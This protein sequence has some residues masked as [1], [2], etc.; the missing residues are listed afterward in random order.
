[1]VRT[2]KSAPYLGNVGLY[3]LR[4][5]LP[6]LFLTVVTPLQVPNDVASGGK[7]R[8]AR[9]PSAQKPGEL[10]GPFGDQSN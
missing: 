3:V 2:A 4:R 1:M 9:G 5:D 8:R 10:A 7:S 6:V